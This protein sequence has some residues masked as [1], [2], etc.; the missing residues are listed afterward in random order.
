[1]VKAK[2]AG[3]VNWPGQ[4]CTTADM[5]KALVANASA[6]TIDAFVAMASVPRTGT[7]EAP[8]TPPRALDPTQ[9][10]KIIT[11]KDK[12][13]DDSYIGELMRSKG[14]EEAQIAKIRADLRQYID[15]FIKGRGIEFD[16][17]AYALVTN[18]L[19]HLIEES[20]RDE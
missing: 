13:L 7:E 20:S 2:N 12:N 10:V 5:P 9:P 3:A 14:L 11:I 8:L 16:D 4:V 15:S 17:G 18:M 19:I 1:M 6:S